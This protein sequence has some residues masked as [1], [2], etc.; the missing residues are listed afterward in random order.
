MRQICILI[1]FLVLLLTF[2][3]CSNFGD[4][5]N[6]PGAESNGSSASINEPS[7]S[8]GDADYVFDEE[9]F[10]E[11]YK[12]ASEQTAGGQ[13]AEDLNL[14]EDP[15][16]T[17]FAAISLDET[18][19]GVSQYLFLPVKNRAMTDEE[20]KALASIT[21]NNSFSL[22]SAVCGTGI[23]GEEYGGVYLNRPLSAKEYVEI[24]WL[25][26]EYLY[27]GRRAQNAADIKAP[28]L[29]FQSNGEEPLVF[30]VLPE[31]DMEDEGL[32]L[33]LNEKYRGNDLSLVLPRD[34]QIEYSDLEPA[35]I[36]ALNDYKFYDG[37]TA[38]FYAIL[39]CTA[40]NGIREPSSEY[41]QVCAA[42]EEG[43]HY[44]MS[45]SSETGELK[46]WTRLPEGYFTGGEYTPLQ[47]DLSSEEGEPTEEELQNAAK[48][49]LFPVADKTETDVDSIEIGAVNPT[50]Y[51][52]MA[53][54]VKIKLKNGT[55]YGVVVSHED[56][57]ICGGTVVK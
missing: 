14:P 45:L 3:G 17:G 29:F 48:E 25:E 26:S 7:V 56:L 21:D 10:F 2:A 49:Y 54:N 42:P 43:F 52:G 35:V 39:I 9:E 30:A 6:G 1:A 32:L 28:P 51:F 5:S 34:G 4:V 15:S 19:Y 44:A 38:P 47:G 13:K 11:A 55:E 46:G 8:V 24:Q 16:E 41:W 33:L 27:E 57:S 53:T 22:D 23:D 37:E 18:V 40:P 31:S 36:K 50:L 12:E 20:M